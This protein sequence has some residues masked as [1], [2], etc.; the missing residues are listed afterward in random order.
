MPYWE[1]VAAPRETRRMV[2]VVV[3]VVVVVEEEQ[4][5]WRSF[6]DNS[7]KCQDKSERVISCQQMLPPRKPDYDALAPA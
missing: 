6:G 3:V 4:H 1:L 2:P 5:H 7:A